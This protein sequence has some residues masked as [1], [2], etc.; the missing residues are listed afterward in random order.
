MSTLRVASRRRWTQIDRRTV[1]DVSL[2][3]RARG[4]LIWLL[5]KPDGWH[6]SAETISAAGGEGRDAIR[7]AL[8]ELETAGYLVRDRRRGRD[9]RWTTEHVVYEHPSLAEDHGGIPAND[10]PEQ[11]GTSPRRETSTGSPTPENQS[12]KT[13]TGNEDCLRTEKNTSQSDLQ[14]ERAERHR[15]ERNRN[16]T[17]NPMVADWGKVQRFA[18]QGKHRWSEN[19]GLSAVARAAAAEVAQTIRY[20]PVDTARVAFYEAWKQITADGLTPMRESVA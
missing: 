3:F 6:V 1:N 10:E 8:T 17:G 11:T 19:P 2:S 18:S 7:S 20:S 4:V 14:R 12:S 15:V 13:E 9:G 16:Q 5:D